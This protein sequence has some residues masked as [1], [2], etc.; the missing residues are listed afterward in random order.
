ML[1]QHYYPFVGGAERQLQSLTSVLPLLQVQTSV[2]TRRLAGPEFTPLA[3]VN[4][5]TVYRIGVHGG[6]AL[7]SLTYT[8]RSLQVIWRHRREIDIL[9]AHELLSPT[10]TAV[11][12]K[13]L[14]RKPIV[15]K[16]LGGGPA[17]DVPKLLHKRLGKTRM[18]LFRHLVDRFICV[19]D[20]IADQLLA[21]GVAPGKL[22]RLPNGVDT[23]AFHPASPEEKSR[24][25]ALHGLPEA[26]LVI[27][28]GRLALE[29]GLRRLLEGWS[30]LRSRC[31]DAHLLIVGEGPERAE[32]LERGFDTVHLL[33]NREDVAEL[34]RAADV[35]ALPSDRE[36]LSNALLEAMATGLPC[37]A[38]AVGG[39]RELLTDRIDGILVQPDADGSSLADAVELALADAELRSRLGAAARQRVESDFSLR[40]VAGKLRDVYD[41]LV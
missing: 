41:G 39:T 11:L 29:K 34:L 1:I 13:L 18:R 33:G 40:A 22:V 35:F 2:L 6:Y 20:E 16:V 17:G 36:G 19:S 12:A 28:T 15:A 37:V 38:T 5:A 31:P 7:R 30:R 24:L 23:E 21:A 25:R 10:T 14:I 3:A 8:A 9:H 32:I 27:Y 26:P 4:G